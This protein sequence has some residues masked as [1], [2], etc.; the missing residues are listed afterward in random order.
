M[1]FS[2]S[3]LHHLE[4]Q[5]E[6]SDSD[7][8]LCQVTV[9]REG[10]RSSI[11]SHNVMESVWPYLASGWQ[12]NAPRLSWG[13]K[14]VETRKSKYRKG[15]VCVGL[16]MFVCGNHMSSARCADVSSCLKNWKTHVHLQSYDETSKDLKL[17]WLEN[18]FLRKWV[19]YMYRATYCTNYLERGKRYGKCRNK[20]IKRTKIAA[21]ISWT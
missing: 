21:P 15:R 10:F 6:S 20:L 8:L 17:L 14:N 4:V 11:T 16:C 19:H 13:K 12:I 2:S 18:I 1:S 7:K 5:I 9:R 3:T